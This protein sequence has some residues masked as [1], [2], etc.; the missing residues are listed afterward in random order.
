MKLET[1]LLRRIWKGLSQSKASRS[2]YLE[3]GHMFWEHLRVL[4]NI[5]TGHFPVMSQ[6]SGICIP[7][8]TNLRC[9]IQQPGHSQNDTLL[10]FPT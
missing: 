4:R 9:N 2:K 5:L 3:P 8:L 1:V 10:I 7:I 6:F